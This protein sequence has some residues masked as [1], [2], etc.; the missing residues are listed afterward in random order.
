MTL[1]ILVADD[2]A[3]NL[4]IASVICRNAGYSVE[5]ARDG[6]E[7]L[8]VLASAGPF[9]L[10]LLDIQMPLLDGLELTRRLR[11]SAGYATVPIIGVTAWVRPEQIG[12]CRGAGMNAVQK[13]PYRAKELQA[14]IA[15]TLRAHQAPHAS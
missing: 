14:L 15:A 2:E 3:N 7:V 4:E 8:A 11:A 6:E 1:R 9:D 13:K 5:V 12:A 10:L